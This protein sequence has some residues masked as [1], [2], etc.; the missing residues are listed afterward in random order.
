MTEIEQLQ[1]AI[2][3]LEA[4]RALLGD[5]VVEAALDS[6]RAR[7]EELKD[8]QT[9]ASEQLKYVT[10]LFTDIV[11]S[12]ARA[13]NLGDR[14]WREVLAEHHRIVRAVVEHH[15]GREVVD[16]PYASIR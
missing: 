14:R 3:E 4:K 5:A 7:I 9:S 11:D 16:F 10:V 13:S 8:T 1:T 15:G 2:L 6:M 12:T